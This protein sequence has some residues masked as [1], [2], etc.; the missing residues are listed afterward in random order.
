VELDDGI[1]LIGSATFARTGTT[2]FDGSAL[3]IADGGLIATAYEFAAMKTGLFGESDRLRISFAQPLHVEDG[4]LEYRS[5][6]VVD[7]ET[8]ELGPYSQT[9]NLSGEREHRLEA[10]YATPVF[11]GRAELNG[12]ALFEMNP[13]SMPEAPHAISV[14]AQ[15]RFAF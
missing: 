4:A 1:A 11:E 8:G 10:I 13:R 9:W 15:I 14:G 7:R 12:F 5:L 3:S 6:Q 2:A